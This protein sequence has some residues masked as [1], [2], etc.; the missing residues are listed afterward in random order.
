MA[1]RILVVD[2]SAAVR[3]SVSYVLDQAGYEVVQAEDGM[4]ALKMLDGSTFDLIVTDVNMPN[5]DGIALTGKVRELDA[6]KY[7]PVVVLTTESQESKMSAGKAAGATGWIVKPF[8]SEKLLQV[9][10]RLAG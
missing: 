10:K 6:Y 1:K 5:M 4:D 7:T 2:D 9:V 8:D 3:Q